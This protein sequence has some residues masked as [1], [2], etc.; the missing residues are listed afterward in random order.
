MSKLLKWI[1]NIILLAAIIIAGGLLIPPLVGVTTFIVDDVDMDTNLAKGSVTYG[2]EKELSELVTGDEILVSESDSECVYRIKSVDAST[3]ACEIEDVKSPAGETKEEVFR[4][5]VTKVLFTIPF[6]GYIVMAMKSTEGLIIIGLA[7]IF[8]VVLF[9]LAELWKKD[10]EEDEEDDDDSEDETSSAPPARVDDPGQIMEKVS[11]EIASAVSSVVAGESI[12]SNVEENGLG[13]DTDTVDAKE[14][15][16]IVAGKSEEP[17]IDEDVL[18]QEL[19]KA[20]GIQ[21]SAGG[22]AVETESADGQEIAGVWAKEVGQEDE[23]KEQGQPEEQEQMTSGHEGEVEEMPEGIE[24][25][26][27]VYTAEELLQKAR[28]AGDEP[29]VKEDEDF[30]VTLLDYSDIL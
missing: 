2:V 19:E 5:S 16:E 28:E 29:E 10:D 30:G 3:G 11:S 25:A 14:I 7:V 17:E 21:S 12:K 1:V 23:P 13:E 15:A 4:K 9:I 6:I 26:M 8:V 22:D 20:Q 27:P 18:V 24:L